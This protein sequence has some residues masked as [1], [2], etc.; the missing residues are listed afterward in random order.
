MEKLEVQLSTANQSASES[1]QQISILKSENSAIMDEVGK[2]K[3]I[4]SE[5]ASD[6]EKYKNYLFIL[7]EILELR[8]YFE[9]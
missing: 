9:A 3:Q 5:N 6:Q 4:I 2:L 7:F 8:S 1:L